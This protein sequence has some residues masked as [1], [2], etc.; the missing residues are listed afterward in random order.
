MLDSIYSWF[1]ESDDQ[2]EYL[3]QV[4]GLS[5]GAFNH[6]ASAAHERT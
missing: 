2:P 5:T 1:D 4:L 6:S 3:T